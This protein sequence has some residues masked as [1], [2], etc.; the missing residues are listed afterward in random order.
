MVHIHHPLARR[1]FLKRAAAMT[2]LTGSPF[3]ANL[4]MMSDAVAQTV[5]DYKALVCVF[6]L[7]GNDHGNTIAPISGANYNAYASARNGIAIGQSS[8]LPIT[9]AATTAGAYSGPAIGLHPA[10]AGVK[11]L[12]DSGRCAV[13]ANVATLVQPTTKA[14]YNNGQ[15]L[16]LQ[17]FSHSDQQ[18]SW[19]TGFP[20]S[21]SQ[22]GWLG[23]VGDAMLSANSGANGASP[24]SMCMSLGG[25]NMIQAGANVIQYQLTTQGSVQ[26]SGISA[27]N[28]LHG[29]AANAALLRQVIE[30]TGSNNLF[31]NEY[32]TIVRRSITADESV[33]AALA[34]APASTGAL[35]ANNPLAA[36]LNLVARMIAA[37]SSLGHK[38]QIYYL[39][40]GGFDF[41]S[42]LLTEQA[43]R[44]A[45]VSSAL[46]AFYNATNTLGVSDRVTTFTAS[47]F[48]RALLANGDGSDHGWGGHHFIVGGAV[49]GGKLY[50]R[51][52]DYALGSVDDV[53]EGRLLPSTSVDE[54]AAVLAR[55]FGVTDLSA[56]LPHVTRFNSFNLDFL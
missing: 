34:T 2:A 48:G 51:F 39:T 12:F 5:T 54:Y 1:A 23:R 28:G 30:Q 43:D 47:D 46:E 11:R 35:L 19:Q 6:L 13:L 38:R 17:L 29:N 27:Q 37:R 4:A 45:L 49:K 15:L 8:L 32:A 53:G 40:L 21:P 56:V 31:E 41:H 26:I 42:N 9:P 7:G 24:V 3:A 52:P 16:P 55:W 50:G 22:T 20:D 10:L 14:Q 44:L 18:N 33:R 36:Q 25:N